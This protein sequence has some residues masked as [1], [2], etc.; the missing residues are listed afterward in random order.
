[1]AK[2]APQQMSKLRRKFYVS[3]VV[4]T[5]VNEAIRADH[6][7]QLLYVCRDYDQLVWQLRNFSSR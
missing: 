7:E 2:G 5:L 6:K 1:M 3:S 4:Y